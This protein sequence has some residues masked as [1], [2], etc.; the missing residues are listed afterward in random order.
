MIGACGGFAIVSGS[1]VGIGI[2]L[3]PS[4]VAEHLRDPFPFFAIWLLGGAI[5][6][7]G[8]VA[9]AELGAMMPEAGGDYVF[10]HAAYGPSVA[11]ATG[12]VLFCAVFAGSIATMAVA[13]CKYEIATLIGVDLASLQ[14]EV[15][16]LASIDG[17]QLGAVLIIAMLTATNTLGAKWSARAQLALTLMPIVLL[18][19]AASYALWSRRFPNV[20]ETTENLASHATTL[21]GW[22]LAYIA[23]YFAYSG[24]TNVLYV[25]G[26]IAEPEHNIPR[27]LIYGIATV[28]ALYLLLCAGFVH[29]LGMSGVRAA[30]E[31]GTAV[32]T[33][34]AGDSGRRVVAFLVA[35]GLL[36]CTNGCVLAGARV[37][38]AMSRRGMMWSALS[39][40]GSRSQV[41][42]TAL[43]VQ[44][45]VS[46][47]LALSGR[48]EELYS[49]VSLAMVTTG[50]L[51]VGSLF[52]LR[53][54]WPTAPRPYR[55]SGYPLVPALY[56]VGALV[57]I[58][59]SVGQAISG[60][61]NDWY[62]LVGI[63]ILALAYVSHRMRGLL[64]TRRIE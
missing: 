21:H 17:S 56:V 2:F 44:A 34:L 9:Y 32:A 33:V 22:S 30:G 15:P 58:A 40:L 57:V 42:I 50:A 47:G 61:R 55:A 49:M 26:E 29:I 12:W 19:L 36:A 28:T 6:L 5:S 48:F 37:A 64:V 35:L 14:I 45:A 23:V 27:S 52:V 31:A 25:A 18:A 62:P 16:V 10:Q 7:A 46:A 13:T 24:W 59:T 51:T 1:M 39:R 41:P 11:F 54:K 53:R 4:L 43:W 20:V 60:S 3:S 38:Y 63:A 8:S